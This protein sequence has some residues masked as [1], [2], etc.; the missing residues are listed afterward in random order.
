[1][2]KNKK[3]RKGKGEK[4]NWEFPNMKNYGEQNKRIFHEIGLKEIL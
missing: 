3:E 1:M 4:F 2:S